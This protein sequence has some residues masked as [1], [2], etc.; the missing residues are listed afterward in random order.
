M[1]GY[2]FPPGN[3]VGSEGEVNAQ[4]WVTYEDSG[5]NGGHDRFGH[6]HSDDAESVGPYSGLSVTT[7]LGQL[8]ANDG[9]GSHVVPGLYVDAGGHL[10]DSPF[11]GEGFTGAVGVETLPP[12]KTKPQKLLIGSQ[13]QGWA[14]FDAQPDPGTP[15]TALAYSVRTAGVIGTT[16]KPLLIDV[17]AGAKALGL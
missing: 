3:F 5:A 12:G 8:L 6:G 14:T 2:M 11:A 15:G 4:P 1:A 7:A 17:F 10:S 16:G 13:A 9:R